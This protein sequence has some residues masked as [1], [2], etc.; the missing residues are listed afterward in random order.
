MKILVFSLVYYPRFIGGA[1]VAIKEITDRLDENEYHMITLRLDK[2]LPKVEKIGNITIHRIG[3]TGKCEETADSLKF[4]L[5]LN[6]HLLPFLGFLKAVSLHKKYSF[7]ATWSMMA[8]YNSFA[9]LFFKIFNPKVP[10]LLTLQEGDPPEHIKKRARSVWPLFKM[11]FKKA[12]HIQVISNF[13]ADFAKDMGYEKEISLVPNG[14]DFEFFAK[15]DEEKIS[16][17]KQKHGKGEKVWVITTSRLVTKN[18]IG[19]VID[20]LPTLSPNISF[21]ILGE[22]YQKKELQER[23]E[24]LQLTERVHFLG[25]VPHKEMPAYLQA[26]DIFIRPSLS[27]GFGNSFIE[28]MASDIPVLA[29]E[30]GGIVDFIEHKKTGLFV[31]VKDPQDIALKIE[32]LLK[33]AEL[34]EEI[35]ENARG[36]VREKYDWNIVSEEMKKVFDKLK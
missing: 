14:V 34:R 11:I 29:T 12:D 17:I 23:V 3:F 22:G 20:A 36:M 32:M 27:E 2:R 18:A 30:V 5:K 15:R 26:S 8:T 13:L 9:A 35:V 33:D 24:K 25:Y 19:D 21:L 6:K 16:E 4:P 10:F 28:A 31:G 7:D 1:E